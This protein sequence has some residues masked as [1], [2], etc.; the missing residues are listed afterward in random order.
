[1]IR[2]MTDENCLL[3]VDGIF[4]LLYPSG[5]RCDRL[6]E[7]RDAPSHGARSAVIPR[8]IGQNKVELLFDVFIP[9]VLAIER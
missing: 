9:L 6:A 1:M 8:R 3:N 4:F 7:L 5:I 2:K